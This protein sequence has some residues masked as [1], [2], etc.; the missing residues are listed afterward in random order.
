MKT[1]LTIVA[2]TSL[3][4]SSVSFART[5]EI[6]GTVM[7]F[8]SDYLTVQKGDEIW[9]IKRGANTKVTGQVKVGETVSVN[10]EE[11]DAKK[12]EPRPTPRPTPSR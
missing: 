8:S 9:M 5:R 12:A 1:L 6:T 7:E 3:L 11:E 2:T 4:L 10:Y